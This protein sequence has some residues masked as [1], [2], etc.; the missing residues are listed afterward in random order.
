MLVIGFIITLFYMLLIGSLIFGYHKVKSFKLKKSVSETTFSII[1][2]FR[3]EAENLPVL[4][5]SIFKL[6]YPKH[7]YEIIFVDDASEDESANIIQQVLD[8]SRLHRDTRTD[9]AVI[10]NERK[11][12]SP[13]KDAITSAINLAKHKWIITTDA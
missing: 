3:N 7:L 4:L 11:T 10:K 12:K 1:V 8:T 6:K 2:P 13:K 5:E 9:M